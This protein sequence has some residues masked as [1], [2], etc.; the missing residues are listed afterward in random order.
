[1]RRIFKN[2]SNSIKGSEEFR[3]FLVSKI[4]LNS[5]NAPNDDA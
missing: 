1:M 4:D 5:S 3:I 2:L